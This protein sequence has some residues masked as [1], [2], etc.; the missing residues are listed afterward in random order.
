M[1]A[2]WVLP[3]V[4]SSTGHS[5]YLNMSLCHKLL[6]LIRVGTI[7]KTLDYQKAYQTTYIHGSQN[8]FQIVPRSKSENLPDVLRLT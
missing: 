8:W 1:G 4:T 2:S 5:V 3:F 7:C 6:M